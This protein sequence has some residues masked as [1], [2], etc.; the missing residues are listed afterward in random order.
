M[1]IYFESDEKSG[2]EFLVLGSNPS[3]PHLITLSTAGA[4]LEGV[5]LRSLSQAMLGMEKL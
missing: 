2:R 3:H 5:R 1:A 4:K